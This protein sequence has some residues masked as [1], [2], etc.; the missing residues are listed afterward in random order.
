MDE[1]NKYLKFLTL[2]FSQAIVQSR[3]GSPIST[4]CSNVGTEWVS[5]IRVIQKNTVLIFLY[6]NKGQILTTNK[7]K[8]NYI[9][10]LSSADLA[11]INILFNLFY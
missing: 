10:I 6:E 7:L 5:K 3:L 11:Y 9:Y 2:K 1:I 8:E 4:K